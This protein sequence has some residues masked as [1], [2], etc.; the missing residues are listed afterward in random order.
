LTFTA[1]VPKLRLVSG[2]AYGGQAYER[3]FHDRTIVRV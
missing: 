2:Q 1:V 3:E